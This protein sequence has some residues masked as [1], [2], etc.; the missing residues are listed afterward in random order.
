[1]YAH[2]YISINLPVLFACCAS[3]HVES[4]FIDPVIG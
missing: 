2:L 1:M 4:E 3:V